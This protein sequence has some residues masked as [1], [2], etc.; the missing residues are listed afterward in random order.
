MLTRARAQQTLAADELWRFGP[1][2]IEYMLILATD[3]LALSAHLRLVKSIQIV[4]LMYP[5]SLQ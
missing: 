1:H 2:E 5:V 4:R 3:K